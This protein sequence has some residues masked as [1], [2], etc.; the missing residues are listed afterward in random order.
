MPNLC[1]TPPELQQQAVAALRGG[2]LGYSPKRPSSSQRKFEHTFT[3]LT[4]YK[5]PCRCAWL[6]PSSMATTANIVF[7]LASCLILSS[8]K[9]RKL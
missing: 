6:S 5:L 7:Y 8:P 3:A 1:I 9:T 2:Y 4:D